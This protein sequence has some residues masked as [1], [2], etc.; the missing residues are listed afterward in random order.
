MKYEPAFPNPQLL[1][2]HG[3]TLRDYFA[4]KIAEVEYRLV[5]DFSDDDWRMNAAIN[6]YLMADK[7][8]MA[9]EEGR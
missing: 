3:M 5:I 1:H 7:M 6:A 9:R 4:A 8:L 2:A